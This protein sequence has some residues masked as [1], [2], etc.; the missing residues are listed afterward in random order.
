[1]NTNKEILRLAAKAADLSIVLWEPGPYLHPCIENP[2]VPSRL[3]LWNPMMFNKDALQLAVKLKMS[4]TIFDDAIGIGV[5]DLG[6]QEYPVGD[7]YESATRMA[8]TEAASRV[9]K[10]ML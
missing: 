7:D 6:Y 8:I 2:D 4:V 9:G 10:N 3:L 1:M 5:P